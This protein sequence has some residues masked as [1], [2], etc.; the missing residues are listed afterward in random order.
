MNQP[1]ETFRR[2][3]EARRMA[4]Y[5]QEDIPLGEREQSSMQ[6]MS[7]RFDVPVTWDGEQV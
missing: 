3:H 6:G 1:P 4:D 2:V 7:E 5:R